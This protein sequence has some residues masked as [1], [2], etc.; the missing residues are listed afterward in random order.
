M[1]RLYIDDCYTFPE[2]TREDIQRGFDAFED[3]LG[4]YATVAD[5]LGDLDMGANLGKRQ[6]SFHGFIDRREDDWPRF[7]V[8]TACDLMFKFA[9][10][11]IYE[12]DLPRTIMGRRTEVT[13]ADDSF[14]AVS[15]LTFTVPAS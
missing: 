2:A 14:S 10:G 4:T 13:A 6:L 15:E 7:Y 9:G 3:A 12:C 8:A 5:Q 11:L 1:L